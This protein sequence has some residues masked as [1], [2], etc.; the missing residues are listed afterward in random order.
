MKKKILIGILSIYILLS[1]VGCSSE[2][3]GTPQSEDNVTTIALSE[4]NQDEFSEE[5]IYYE[6]YSNPIDAYFLPQIEHAWS[7]ADR[8]EMQD[9]YL[10]VW[11]SEFE[12]VMLWM[13]NKCI[14]QED[15]DNLL[16]YTKSVEA[17]IETTRTIL[18]TDWLDDYKLPPDSGDR[19]F[20]G[21]G[22]RSGLNQ[23]EAE[24]YRDASLKLINDTYI[25]ME[26]D[27]SLEH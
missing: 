24:I 3:K 9:I 26:R 18:V 27:Y 23:A 6:V 7:Q 13:Q 16:L 15:K 14:Y 8:R 25:F 4:N 11:K 22:T 20:W 12:N 2:P 1:T 10:D 19:N 5:C 17:L 21:N